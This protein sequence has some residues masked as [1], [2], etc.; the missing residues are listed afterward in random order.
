MEERMENF[1][2]FVEEKKEEVMNSL[3]T[4]DGVK[5]GIKKLAIGGAFAAG[6][7]AGAFTTK[8][9]IPGAKKFGG[10]VKGK[11]TKDKKK[12]EDAETESE[13]K[14]ENNDSDK[15]ETKDEKKPENNQKHGK[16]KR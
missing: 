16:K 9:V 5:G 11:F 1:E 13:E 3:N 8:V 6:A 14:E 10:W 15:S 12:T 2:N 4:E 7:A